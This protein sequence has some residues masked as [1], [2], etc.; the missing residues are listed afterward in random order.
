MNSS[1]SKTSM[2]QDQ[3]VGGNSAIDSSSSQIKT[4]QSG[5]DYLD[6]QDDL[7]E[8]IARILTDASSEL[9]Y[10]TT[11]D[12]IDATR[13]GS[14]N[15]G[16]PK[17]EEERTGRITPLERVVCVDEFETIAKIKLPVAT[18]DYYR[19]GADE[20]TT[21]R[22]NRSAITE[23]YCLRPR[24]MCDVSKVDLT[25]YIYGDKVSM[26]IGLSP[27]SM[28]K[29]AHPDG[30]KATVRAADRSNALMVL[31]MFST[32]SL[33]D[34]AKEAPICVK[35][36]NLYILKN[37]EI[38]QNIIARAI[39]FGYRAI[40]VTCDAPI[41]GNRRHN[42]KNNFTLGDHKLEN[43]DDGRVKSMR[44]HSSEI[45]DPSVTW[46]DLADL[47]KGVGD[48][49]RVIA[50]GIMTPEDAEQALAA[51][52]DGIWVSNH[53][54]RQLDGTQ[55]TIKALPAI[56]RAVNRRCPVFVDSGFRTGADVLKALAIGADMVFVGRTILWGLASYGEDGVYRALE[57]LKDE[58]HRAMMLCGC[59][60]LSDINRNLVLERS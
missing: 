11:G 42:T 17:V 30:E 6:E 31:S 24:V 12:T 27:T 36:Q 56:V 50:K 40:V 3:S 1:N 7:S 19:G 13:M 9:D 23:C 5:F 10:H 59:N 43:I 57:I 58:L 8:E 34:V 20:E 46:Q 18:Y 22:W 35:W 28:H 48:T 39:R 4:R 60:K 44:E 32:T 25:K 2:N 37:R 15:N 45:F 26:P 47:K 54:G 14:L 38:T 21:L 49:I 52:V 41:L 29:M 55:S 51:G 53:G 16:K 33:E